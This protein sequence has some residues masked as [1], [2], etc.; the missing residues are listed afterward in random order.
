MDEDT[1]NET[2]STEIVADRD[3]EETVSIRDTLESNLRQVTELRGEESEDGTPQRQVQQQ[4]QQ[5]HR[6]PPADMRKEERE[7]WANPTPE[8]TKGKRS[9]LRCSWRAPRQLRKERD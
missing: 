4:Q 9:Y 7:A 6:V 5:Q 3:A 2:E 1:G 8:N